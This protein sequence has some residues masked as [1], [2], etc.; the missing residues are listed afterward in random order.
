MRLTTKNHTFYD[1]DAELW[2]TN[3]G[4]QGKK[5]IALLFSCW[6]K[7]EDESKGRA[8]ALIALLEYGGRKKI[9]IKKL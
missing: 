5:E 7:T 8:S 9:K 3:V 1:A 2:C 4:R 6:G